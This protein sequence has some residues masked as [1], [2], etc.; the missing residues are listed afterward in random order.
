ME[1]NTAAKRHIH[2]LGELEGTYHDASLLLGMSD[3]VSQILYTIC[4]GGGGCPLHAICRQCGLSKQTVNSAVRKL[5]KEGI[6]YL[7]A[8]DGKA[9]RVCLTAA[10]EVYAASPPG[11]S[12]GWRT[13]SWMPGRRRMW[14]SMRL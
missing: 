3:S 14:S 9:K 10:G 8:M 7:E 11:R 13:R 5:E 6:V 2:L 1:G 4:V 12:S